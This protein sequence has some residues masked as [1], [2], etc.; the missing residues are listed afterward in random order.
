MLE[1]IITKEIYLSKWGGN[2]EFN[3]ILQTSDVR[4]GHK[5]FNHIFKS[6][7]TVIRKISKIKYLIWQPI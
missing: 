5:L 4:V 2:D 3:S 1:I 6:D 7:V